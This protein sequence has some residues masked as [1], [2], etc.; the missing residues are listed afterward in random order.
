M[1]A[2]SLFEPGFLVVWLPPYYSDLNPIERIWRYL[3][4]QAC[5]NHLEDDI[6]CV[7]QQAERTISQQSNP[8]ADNRYHISKNL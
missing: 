4:N 3:K 5:A 8:D 1:A 7:L 6:A 2:P